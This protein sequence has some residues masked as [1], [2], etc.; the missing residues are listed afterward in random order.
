MTRQSA[1]N[2]RVSPALESPTRWTPC[3]RTCVSTHTTQHKSNDPDRRRN[4]HESR[5]TLISLPCLLL[6]S[7]C[8]C[9]D[10]ISFVACDGCLYELDGRKSGPVNHGATTAETLLQDAVK[11]IQG[12]MQRDPDAVQFNMVAL[13]PA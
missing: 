5:S 3:K 13:G 12:F 2:M 1:N 9:A 10:F 4:S 7:P 11:V 6:L 8:S